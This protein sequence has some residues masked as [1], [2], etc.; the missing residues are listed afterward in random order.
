MRYALL[1]VAVVNLTLVV[2]CSG[3]GAAVPGA[4][5]KGKYPEPVTEYSGMN[6]KGWGKQA[7]DLNENACEQAARALKEIGNEGTPFL[8]AAI[9]KQTKTDNIG[10]CIT[11]LNGKHVHQADL[12]IVAGFLKEK[13]PGYIQFQAKRILSEAGKP[14]EKYLP[15]NKD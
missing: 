8:L 11:A 10:Y 13:Y 9:S 14:G 7:L 3:Q 6:A 12:P 2:G 5:T 1:A 15:K 4:V